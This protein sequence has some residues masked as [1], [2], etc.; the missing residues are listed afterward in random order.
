MKVFVPSTT[1]QLMI[2]KLKARGADVIVAG[3]NWN[4]ADLVAREEAS[5]T[6]ADGG[7]YVP[8]FNHPLI[9][10]G[11]SSIMHELVSDGLTGVDC[12]VVAVGGGGLLCGV[13]KGIHDLGWTSTT[14]V[15]AVETAG[16]ASFAAA[17][18]AGR[19]VK[20]EKIDTVATSLGALEV[21]PETLQVALGS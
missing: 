14:S 6:A 1:K 10:E 21:V 19:P 5:K 18:N 17:K 16:A 13:Q 12:V 20:L 7:L 11:N 15:I 8:P 9:W 3:P 4:S 2:E